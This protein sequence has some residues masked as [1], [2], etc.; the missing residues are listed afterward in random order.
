MKILQINT[1]YKNGGSTGRIVYDLRQLIRSNGDEA[2][3]AYGYEFS[4]L[5]EEDY[6]DTLKMCSYPQLQFS[7]LQTRIFAHHG[8]YNTSETK[9]LLR[10]ID[11]IKPDLIHLHNIHNHY[12][13]VKLL[14]DYIKQHNMPVVWTLHDCWSFTGWCSHFD[15]ARCDKWKTGCEGF[16]S[17]KHD[18]PFTWFSS[19]NAVN[20]KNKKRAFTGVEKMIIVTPSVWL[21]VLVRESFLKEYPV[22]VVNNGVNLS[23]FKPY[24]NTMPARLKYGI[25]DKHVILALF[26][27]FSK[28]KGTDYLMKLTDYLHDD[29]VLVVVGIKQKEM[30]KLP[31]H[32]CIGICHTDSIQELA[33]IYSL[34]DVFVN[35]TLQDN[36]PT[37][38]LE[39]LACGTPVVTFRTGGSV[40]SVTSETG[41]IVEQGDMD[42]LL[43]AIRM[44]IANGKAQY[45]QVCR[46]KAEREYNKDVQYGK[47]RELYKRILSK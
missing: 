47:Y 35:P 19:Q 28:Y 14:F 33:A 1:T 30:D 34:A 44:V 26:N 40:E 38:N 17:C 24:D 4:A 32:H 41:L 29:E 23:V 12:I 13:N 8:F 15:Y 16:C 6:K 18:Y 27:T 37:T 31:K 42:G 9:K 20:Y 11:E 22:K 7:K 39:A 2:Y 5:N 46:Q 10:W 36:F 45:T 21:S 43:S 25:G 3:V